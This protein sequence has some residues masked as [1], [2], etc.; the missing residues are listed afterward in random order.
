[1]WRHGGPVR[2]AVVS[3]MRLSRG[4]VFVCS[5]SD[6]VSDRMLNLNDILIVDHPLRGRLNYKEWLAMDWI[7]DEAVED[8]Y[9]API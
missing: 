3:A 4:E 1:M 8:D 7:P 5:T 6:L 9:L 2:I